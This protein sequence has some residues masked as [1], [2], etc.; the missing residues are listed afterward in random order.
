MQTKSTFFQR[1]AH[2]IAE[3][4]M[5]TVEVFIKREPNGNGMSSYDDGIESSTSMAQR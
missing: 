4:L 5:L 3:H 2:A 1:V